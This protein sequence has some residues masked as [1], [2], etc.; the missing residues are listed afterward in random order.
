MT[1]GN[2]ISLVVS[3]TGDDVAHDVEVDVTGAFYRLGDIAPHQTAHVNLEPKS[4]SAIRITAAGPNAG[5][6][7]IYEGDYIEPG[8]NGRM[9]V[10]FRSDRL[11]V[12]RGAARP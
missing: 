3:N 9:L 7:V 2:E 6:S 4:E 12:V 8:Y 10:E 5:R 11:V 1:T